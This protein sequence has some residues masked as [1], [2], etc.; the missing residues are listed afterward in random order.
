MEIKAKLNKPYTSK[1]RADFIVENN[2]NKGYK[3]QETDEAL[4]AVYNEP[5]VKEQKAEVRAVR[6]NLLQETDK[7]LIIDYPIS[8]EEKEKYKKYRTYLRNY[9]EN[10][11]WYLQKPQT[12]IEFVESFNTNTTKTP[13][14]E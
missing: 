9:T 5:T 14:L 7:Y 11:E 3:I 10:N 6:D 13:I 2:H 12:F 1:Q 8:A 4:L